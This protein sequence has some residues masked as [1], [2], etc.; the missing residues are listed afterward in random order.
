MLCYIVTTIS[1]YCYTV[2]LYYAYE[3]CRSE[4]RRKE[5]ALLVSSGFRSVSEV[6]SVTAGRVPGDMLY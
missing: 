1:S 6:Y 2:L 3:H 4:R 5:E